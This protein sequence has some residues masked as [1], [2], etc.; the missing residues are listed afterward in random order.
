MA[1]MGNEVKQAVKGWWG[2]QHPQ[3]N[4]LNGE[5]TNTKE[6]ISHGRLFYFIKCQTFIFSLSLS[7]CVALT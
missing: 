6:I 2:R 7:L 1:L 5:H 4:R 3:R